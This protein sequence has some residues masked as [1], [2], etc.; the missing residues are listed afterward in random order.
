MANDL[1]TFEVLVSGSEPNSSYDII[2][3]HVV[4]EF[5]RITYAK[6]K[7]RDGAPAAQDFPITDGSDF[8]PGNE[9][10]IKMGFDSKNSTVFKGVVTGMSIRC[11]IETGPELEIEC[12][13]KAV[14]MTIAR[15]SAYYLKKKDS[16]VMSTLIGNSG[17]SAD[18]TATSYEWPE[19]IQYYATDWDFVVSRADINGM[20]VFN[21]QNKVTVK[22]IEPGSS[23]ATFTYGVDIYAFTADMDSKRQLGTV[24]TEGWSYKNQSLTTANSS[25]PST[26]GQGNLTGKKLSEVVA[27]SSF[28]LQST[29][30]LEDAP[31]K[32]W[33]DAQLVKSR[34]AKIRGT[35]KILGTA[36]I[37]PGDSITVKGM[38]ERFSG[39][40]YVS[41]IKQVLGNGEWYTMVTT[42]LDDNWFADLVHT[43]AKPASGLLPGVTGVLNATVKKIDSDPDSETRVQVDIPVIDP[44]GDG[45][46]A[47]LANQYATSGAGFFWMP[48]VGDE[49]IVTFLND[50]PRYPVIIGSLYSSQKAPPLTPDEKNTKKAIYSREKIYIE[51]DDENKI[52]TMTTPGENK[53]I[54]SDQD[55]QITIQDQNSNKVVMSESGI[56][57]SSP[58]DIDIKA[59]GN[60]NITGT[61]GV[62]IKSDA[63][64]EVEA[65]ANF[66][67]KGLEISL[68]ADTEFKAEGSAAA[69]IQGGGELTLKGGIVMIN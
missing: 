61:G 11:V 53:M 8:L 6:I 15:N 21:D 64:V 66:T 12:R 34:F 25:E 27:P 24:E 35:F 46:W 28:K 51:F 56:E 29:G 22:K 20:I 39:D 55:K 26:P 2:S 69:S 45:V 16:D 32:S 41:G 33:A 38:G 17:A 14:K 37:N 36:T 50:D 18:V 63:N 47:R 68:T 40:A 43:M 3:I 23:A 59:T 1:A 31:L 42:G 19:I 10:E 49:V 9:I 62:T 52:L 48:E 60:V 13:D 7:L 30:P 5:N 67:G 44:S 4:K 54:Y 58:K 57:M 65:T